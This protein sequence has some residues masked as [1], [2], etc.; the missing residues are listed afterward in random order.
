QHARWAGNPVVVLDV[1]L[2]SAAERRF[3]LSVCRR[4]S[5]ALATVAAG[6][7]ATLRIFADEGITVDAVDD[8]ADPS[9]DLGRLRRHIFMVE[10]PPERLRAGDVCVFSAPGEAREA[11]EIARRALD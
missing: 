9:T 5:A 3:A 6:D 1:P 2:A 10:P 4:A 7:E 8:D 11:L